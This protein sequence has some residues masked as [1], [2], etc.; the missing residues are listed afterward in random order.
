MTTKELVQAL[1][2]RGITPHDLEDTVH[3]LVTDRFAP[4]ANS[5]SIGEDGEVKLVLEIAAETERLTSAGVDA[6]VNWMA[7]YYGNPGDLE[8]ALHGYLNLPLAA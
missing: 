6:Q 4:A 1:T 7:D 3:A 8:L 2:A 5:S